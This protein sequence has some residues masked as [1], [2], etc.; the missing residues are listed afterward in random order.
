M[1]NLLAKPQITAPN[2]EKRVLLHACCAPCSCAI[3]EAVAD[4]G[5]DCTVYFYNPNIFP[6]DEY[7]LRKEENKRFARRCGIPFVDAD[8]DQDNWFQRVK[9]LECE[10]ERGRRCRVCFSMRFERAALYAHEHGFKVFASSLGISRW[11]NLDQVNECGAQ[12][13]A[14]Y[15]GLVFLAPN[16]RKG[17]REQQK[18]EI[19]RREEFYQQ[20]YCGCVYSL[21]H[22]NA[23]RRQTGKEAV[24]IG[25]NYYM[26]RAE[27]VFINS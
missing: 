25:E 12:A 3:I 20:E 27:E 23:W 5:F 8:Y 17:G 22:T 18:I 21:R 14:R 16:W 26:A 10:P 13:A 9:G 19:I 2:G 24:R 6:R 4:A 11:K 7:E 1:Q 15:Q